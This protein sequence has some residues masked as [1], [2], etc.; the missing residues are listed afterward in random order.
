MQRIANFTL[1]DQKDYV[2]RWRKF[3]FDMDPRPR[4]PLIQYEQKRWTE[5]KIFSE[6]KKRIYKIHDEK[7]DAIL[8]GGL[9]NV[10]LYAWYLANKLGI[11]VI[12][13][14]TPRKRGKNGGFI[15]VLEGW[16][17]LLRLDQL[18]GR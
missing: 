2:R 12:M 9:S 13:A 5:E 6:V 10:M 8:I 15:F 16:Q 11:R 1:H 7:Y 3:G 17:E 4:A 18:E 14:K